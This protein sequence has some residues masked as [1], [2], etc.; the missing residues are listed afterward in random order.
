MPVNPDNIDAQRLEKRREKGR[1]RQARLAAKRKAERVGMLT[2]RP[3]DVDEAML[4]ALLATQPAEAIAAVVR[5]AFGDLRVRGYA[6]VKEA[7]RR[8][9]TSL[10]PPAPPVPSAAPETAGL[11]STPGR[12]PVTPTQA[13]SLTPDRIADPSHH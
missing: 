12:T 9:C 11:G 3:A 13:N 2:P 1:E 8:R 4:K 5:T 6:G 7:M 10:K